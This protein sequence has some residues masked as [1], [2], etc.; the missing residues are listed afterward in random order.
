MSVR[1][2]YFLLLLFLAYAGV[3]AFAEPGIGGICMCGC[4]NN[5]AAA[6]RPAHSHAACCCRSAGQSPGV[7]TLPHP[8][9]CHCPRC[10]DL[11]V[12]RTTEKTALP[13]PPF[14]PVPM[15]LSC[16]IA[17]QAFPPIHEPV[18]LCN[19][20]G[21]GGWAISCLDTVILRC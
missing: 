18:N 19:D 5:E 13:A 1:R 21:G 11:P 20:D 4:G 2:A 8:R 10:F 12:S 3:S 6:A 15:F 14:T 9:P 17:H 7:G 16:P